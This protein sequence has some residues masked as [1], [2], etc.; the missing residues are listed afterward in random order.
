MKHLVLVLVIILTLGLAC[1]KEVK[2]PTYETPRTIDKTFAYGILDKIKGIWNGPVSSSTPL[3][4]Y[5]EWI[6]DFRPISENQISAKNELDTLNDIH[7]SFFIA[8]YNNEYRVAFRNGGSF[9]GLKR[10]SYFLADSVS[11]TSTQAYYHFSE[12]IKGKSRAST[13]ILFRNDSMVMTVFT[14]KF[15]SLLTPSQHMR[16]IAKLQDNIACAPT[17]AHFTFPKK[18]LT[19][20]FSN[21]FTGQNEAI[22]YSLSDDPYPENQQPYLGQAN[23]SYSYLAGLTPSASKKVFLLITTQPLISG[24][25]VNLANMRYRSRYVILS[26]ADLNYTF[27]YMHPGSYYLYALYDN[28]NNNVLSSGD[29]VSASSTNFNVNPEATCSAATQINYIIP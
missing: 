4:G 25:S 28:D 5:S 1:K 3:G 15:N 22:Y 26:A 29:W 20:D 19:K 13:E 17:V 27:N 12:I 24:F 9:N 2:P 7:M 10:V 21:T 6:V 11:E 23:I 14:N 16:W 18:T 8:F